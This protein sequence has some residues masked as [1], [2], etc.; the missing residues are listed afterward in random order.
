MDH[1]VL[2]LSVP[3]DR[4]PSHA[5]EIADGFRDPHIIG[6]TDV[7]IRIA[8][9]SENAGSALRKGQLR[10]WGAVADEA[11]FLSNVRLLAEACS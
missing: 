4:N 1:I 5:I 6:S 8:L 2:S 9:G 10:V 3:R 7:L 11:K